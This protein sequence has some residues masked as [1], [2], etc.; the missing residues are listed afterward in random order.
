[1]IALGTMLTTLTLAILCGLL[2]FSV[3]LLNLPAEA[4]VLLRRLDIALR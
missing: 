2:Q 4:T 1:M 3:K